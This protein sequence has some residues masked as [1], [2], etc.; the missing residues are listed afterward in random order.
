[1]QSR[2]LLPSLNIWSQSTPH[3]GRTGNTHPSCSAPETQSPLSL[4]S[5]SEPF[6][7]ASR[8]HRKHH[9]SYSTHEITKALTNKT[10]LEHRNTKEFYDS[11]PPP[12][13]LRPYPQDMQKIYARFSENVHVSNVFWIMTSSAEAG[14]RVN[15]R[16]PIQIMS[17]RT[18]P[19]RC[20][21]LRN[22]S[23]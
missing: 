2:R 18:V 4:K 15:P 13:T 23:E 7:T 14:R 16:R 20:N 17:C 11:P 1:M 6:H 3:R 9:P 19:C 10:I 5:H 21:F 8:P 12:R 22:H